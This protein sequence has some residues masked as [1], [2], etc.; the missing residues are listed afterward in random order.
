M[1]KLHLREKESKKD[2]FKIKDKKGKMDGVLPQ[3]ITD[4]TKLSNN[5]Y[6]MSS[7]DG[8]YVL[9]NDDCVCEG[10]VEVW[11][12]KLMETMRSTIR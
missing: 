11:L 2:K 4:P 10:Q 3:S 1:A 12:N 6:A 7:K 8:E 5:A 9:F